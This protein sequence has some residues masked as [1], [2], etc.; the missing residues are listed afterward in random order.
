M[1]TIT[2]L[3]HS[4]FSA[5]LEHH[6]LLFDYYQGALPKWPAQKHLCVFVSHRHPDHFNH[7]IF[8]LAEIYPH[9]TFILSKDIRM[10]QRYMDRIGISEA[11]RNRILYAP[12]NAH[13]SI[14]DTLFAKTLAST[15]EGVAF[16]LTCEGKT[17]YHAGDLNWWTW[18]G[19]E[20]EPEYE[21]MTRRFQAQMEKLCGRHIDIAFLPLDA[22]QKERYYWGFDAF[23]KITDTKAAFPMH[24]FGDYS[25]M[26][27]LQR[28]D[29][30]REYRERIHCMTKIG[31]QKILSL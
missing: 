10:S 20:T 1:I 17:I 31:E 22:R 21:D 15:D 9:I 18:P 19:E 27:R 4:G 26:D 28:E 30:C 23:M 6:V 29:W 2:Y 3:Y 14:D 7:E 5:E 12:K 13:F 8:R 24:C 11:A 16:L 25:V